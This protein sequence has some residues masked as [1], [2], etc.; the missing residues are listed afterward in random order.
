MPGHPWTTLVFIAICAWVVAAVWLRDPLRALE[1]LALTAAGLPV[2]L[3][4]N[5]RRKLT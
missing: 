2:Y 1:G 4:W 3:L 5:R